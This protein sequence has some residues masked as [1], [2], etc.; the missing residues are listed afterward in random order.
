MFEQHLGHTCQSSH[1]RLIL[2]L[3]ARHGGR[4]R[5]ECRNIMGQINC[6][7][8]YIFRRCLAR[9]VGSNILPIIQRERS[10][11]VGRGCFRGCCADEISKLWLLN[12][13]LLG[14]SQDWHLPSLRRCIFNDLGRLFLVWAIAGFMAGHIA[15]THTFGPSS[16]LGVAGTLMQS[17]LCGYS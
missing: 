4:E 11:S 7:G 12:L 15:Q 5:R 3:A 1:T 14:E 10:E 6:H 16:S 2:P 8:L 17:G 9:S 13:G